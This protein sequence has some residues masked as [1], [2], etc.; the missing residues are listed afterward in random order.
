[1]SFMLWANPTDYP[2]TNTGLLAVGKA[3]AP[4]TSSSA[5]KGNIAGTEDFNYEINLVNGYIQVTL[6]DCEFNP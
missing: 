6:G 2:Y 5:L 3:V 4:S 1:M